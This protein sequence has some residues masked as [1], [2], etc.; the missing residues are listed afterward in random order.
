MT[1]ITVPGY[2]PY[3]SPH[4]ERR[5]DM[6]GGWWGAVKDVAKVAASPI[7]LPTTLTAK[8]AVRVAKGDVQGAA[9][10]LW[11]DAERSLNHSV[12]VANSPAGRYA[13]AGVA[14][15]FPPAA[16]AAAGIAA[17]AKV[18]Q[19]AESRD[20]AVRRAAKRT[21]AATYKYASTDQSI[22]RGLSALQAAQA[23]RKRGSRPERIITQV[24]YGT[25]H[26]PYGTRLVGRWRRA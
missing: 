4:D 17:A 6:I 25:L 24:V 22:R 1:D 16:P 13:L 9:T 18:L 5:E 7:T 20:A 12:K 10:G 14:L 11:R 15:A 8:A 3:A 19:S 21:I 23:L 2:D 26:T